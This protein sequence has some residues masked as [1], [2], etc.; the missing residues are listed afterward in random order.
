MPCVGVTKLKRVVVAA[1]SVPYEVF[2]FC[3]IVDWLSSINFQ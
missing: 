2:I 1:M 3:Q